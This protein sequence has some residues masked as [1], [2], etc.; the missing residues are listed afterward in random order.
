M[1]LIELV[2]G[3]ALL[4]LAL[5][6]AI[7]AV[8][9]MVRTSALNA[10]AEEFF[11]DVHRARAEALARNRRVTICKSQEGTRCSASGG[12]QQGWILFHDENGNGAR[13]ST[14]EVIARHA[15]LA[16]QLRVTGN[17][18]V[19]RYVSYSAIGITRLTGGGFQAGTLT[20]CIASAAPSSGRQIVLNALGRPRM[21][22]ATLAA[23]E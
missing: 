11:S 20:V 22:K 8:Q 14:E 13:E 7:P 17:G 23:C 10:A 3:L 18:P 5:R 15:P 12:W 21:Q 19:E 1:T 2:I 4:T 16:Y 6:L 9:D